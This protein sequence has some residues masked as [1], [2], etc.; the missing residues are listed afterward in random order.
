MSQLTTNTTTIDELITM[1]N[2]LPDAGSGEDVSEEVE[3]YTG[4]LTDL[5]SAINELPDAGSG[6]GSTETCTITFNYSPDADNS[7]V[8]YNV[9]GITSISYIDGT[10]NLLSLDYKKP[11]GLF[12][13]TWT[14]SV[15]CLC[16]S[17]V[18]TSSMQSLGIYFKSV[19]VD[20]SITQY[21]LSPNGT[22]YYASS[23]VFISPETSGNYTVN[24]VY[25]TT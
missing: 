10:G 19:T 3:T 22:G 4:L 16:G 12:S 1:A 7:A 18:S 13:E 11:S 25:G 24:V 17:T 23:L 20:E 14:S 21:H 9:G 8:T 2:A 15:T 5:E 6:G